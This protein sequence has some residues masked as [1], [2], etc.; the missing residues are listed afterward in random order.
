LLRSKKACLDF[1]RPH[2]FRARVGARI[3]DRR[4]VTYP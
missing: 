1:F 2:L 4:D 3:S